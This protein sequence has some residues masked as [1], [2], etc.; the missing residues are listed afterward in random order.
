MKLLASDDELAPAVEFL[1]TVRALASAIGALK[2]QGSEPFLAPYEFDKAGWV[3]NRWCELL[4]IS[5]EA[6]QRLMEISD[7]AMRLKLVDEYLRSN[8]GI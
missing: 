3:A 5:I 8:G 2:N 7:A 6:K 4:P 1:P